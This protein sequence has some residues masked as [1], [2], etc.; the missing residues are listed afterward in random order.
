MKFEADKIKEY[1]EILEND[2]DLVDSLEDEV[3]DLLV[4]YLE[5]EIEKK[6]DLLDKLIIE[7][8]KNSD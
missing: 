5:Q 4:E 3:V 6:E 1:V 2:L 8:E 7:K